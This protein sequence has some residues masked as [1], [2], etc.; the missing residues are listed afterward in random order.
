[1]PDWKA[2]SGKRSKFFWLLSG[3]NFYFADVTINLSR[4]LLLLLLSRTVTAFAGDVKQ[5]RLEMQPRYVGSASCSSSSCHG[6]AGE[7]HNQFLVWSQRDFHTKAFLILTTARSTQIAQSLGIENASTSERCTVCHSPMAELA[8]ARLIRPAQRDEGV[9]CESCHGPAEEWLRSHT[10]KDYTYAMRV[11]SGLRDLRNIY[12]RANACVACHELT[13]REI[14]NSGHPPLFFELTR[15]MDLEPPHW[16]ALGESPARTW[17]CGQATALRE[18]SWKSAVPNPQDS[19]DPVATQ[20]AALAW[21][22]RKA[23]SVDQAFP[24]ISEDA[25]AGTMQQMA[26]EL[27]RRAAARD[28]KNSYASNLIQLLSKSGNDFLNASASGDARF[29][30]AKRLVLAFQALISEDERSYLPELS[31]LNSDVFSVSSFDANK[32]VRDLELMHLK[33][34]RR[35]P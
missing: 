15:Q 6:G 26:D 10:R 30:R 27:A 24:Q 17:L 20:R 5:A 12:V 11:S 2:L 21:L 35:P 34:E 19:D 31:E 14:A 18:L 3:L 25:D 33:V 8:S 1:L 7:Q 28:V 22:L 32:F 16:R 13:D 4:W 9:A 23:T 29:Y